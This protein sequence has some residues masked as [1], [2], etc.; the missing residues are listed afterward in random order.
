[1]EVLRDMPTAF[2]RWNHAFSHWTQLH[3]TLAT[4]TVLLSSKSRMIGIFTLTGD[5]AEPGNHGS[6]K[7]GA[8]LAWSHR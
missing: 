5:L 8:G 6:L 4:S 2:K 1:M 7:D 3:F